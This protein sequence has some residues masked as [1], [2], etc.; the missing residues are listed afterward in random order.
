MSDGQEQARIDETPALETSTAEIAAEEIPPAELP[1][2]KIYPTIKNAVL[3]C[4]LF[5]GIQLG[6]SIVFGLLMY[7]VFSP[8]S[9]LLSVICDLLVYLLSFGLIIWIGFRKT[10]RSFNEV[11]K[12][13]NVSADLWVSAVVL[14]VGSVIVISELDNL[15]NYVLPMPEFFQNIFSSMMADKPLAMAIIYIG[16]APAFMEEFL[17][18]GL[19]LDGFAANYSKRKAIIIS[20]LLFGIIHLNPWQFFTGFLF[21]IVL[22]WVCIETKSI[23]LCVFLH[24]FNNTLYTL[25]VRFR[26]LIPIEGFNVTFEAAKFQ[27]WWFTLSGA[28]LTALGI[29][30]MMSSIKR[31]RAIEQEQS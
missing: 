4:L 22:A 31:E 28:A 10:K 16:I 9:S 19:I 15:F 20:A 18:R 23:L 2:K 29:W 3:L 12:F 27:P 17:F 21:G 1:V 14:A 13:K 6:M 11:F 24:F 7:Y 30:L 8:D 26:D 5:L 25:V